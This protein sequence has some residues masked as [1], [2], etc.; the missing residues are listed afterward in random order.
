M[1]KSEKI[2]AIVAA[3]EEMDERTVGEWHDLILHEV[4]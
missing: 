1:S 2:E 3:L 4:E